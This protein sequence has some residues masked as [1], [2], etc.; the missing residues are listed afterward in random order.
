MVRVSYDQKPYRKIVM[1]LYGADVTASPSTKTEFGRK[2][3]PAIQ[4]IPEAW[5]LP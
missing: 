5:E 2:I 4:I 3:L 1:Q